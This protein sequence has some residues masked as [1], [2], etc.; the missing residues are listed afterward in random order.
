MRTTRSHTEALEGT[1]A[2]PR[3][4]LLLIKAYE[5]VINVLSNGSLG[6]FL[7]VAT[8]FHNAESHLGNRVQI[9]RE[10]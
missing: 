3:V 1:P 9:C 10:I 8:V 5:T 2:Q 7:I 4:G 6:L